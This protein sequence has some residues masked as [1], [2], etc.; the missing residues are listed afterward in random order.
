M[1]LVLH[2]P[3]PP[4]TRPQERAA[5]MAECARIAIE[6]VQGRALNPHAIIITPRSPTIESRRAREWQQATLLGERLRGPSV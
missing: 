4:I 6:S 1:A 2:A 5:V 3:I